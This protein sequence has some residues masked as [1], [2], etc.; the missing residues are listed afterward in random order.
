VDN[1]PLTAAFSREKQ[2]N[3]TF[4]HEKRPTPFTTLFFSRYISRRHGWILSPPTR[5]ESTMASPKAP[6]K[7]TVLGAIAEETTLTRKQVAA[8]FESLS[9]QI[10][11]SLGKKGPGVFAIPGLVKLIVKNK[12]ATK[13]GTRPNPFKPG[14]MMEVKA[15]P[16]SRTV[17]ARPLKGLKE[18][19]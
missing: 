7:G 16:A 4:S 18:L 8:V 9:G 13:A 1:S 11:K 17:R 19:I 6:S 5:K 12:P 10:K 14:E 2:G 3:A 15:K